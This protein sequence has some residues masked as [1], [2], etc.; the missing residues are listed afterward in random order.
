MISKA[1]KNKN[2]I[3]NIKVAQKKTTLVLSILFKKK[4]ENKLGLSS[5]KL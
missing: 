3:S 4:S 5:A 2:E 1:P